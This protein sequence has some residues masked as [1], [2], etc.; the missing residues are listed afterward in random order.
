MLAQYVVLH[1]NGVTRIPSHLSYEEG[2][3]LPCAAVTAWNALTGWML[4]PGISVL[5]QGTGGVSMFALQFAKLAGARVI[6]TSSSDDKLRRAAELGADDGINYKTNP[7][8]DSEAVKRT[9]GIGV[10]HIIEVGGP[11]TLGRSMN[12]VRVGG[13]ISVIG[14]LA[15]PEASV[16]PMPIL[17]KQIQV[18]GIFVGSRDMFETMNRAIALHT[19]RPVVDRV[20]KFDEARDALR[21]MQSGKHFGKIVVEVS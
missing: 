21:Y 19:L 7:D 14:L 1:E 5:V 9:G 16:S 8:W 18:Q 10:D 2:A 6:V 12:A 15:G 13:R 11:A 4:K 20:F 17:G 3:T